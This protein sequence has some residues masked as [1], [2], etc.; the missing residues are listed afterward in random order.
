MAMF[1]CAHDLNLMERVL[2]SGLCKQQYNAY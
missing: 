1:W 2:P